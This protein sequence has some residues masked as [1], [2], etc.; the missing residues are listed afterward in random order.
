MTTVFFSSFSSPSVACTVFFFVASLPSTAFLDK[1]LLVLV[2][3]RATGAANWPFCVFA[4]S[5]RGIK[6]S[7]GSWRTISEATGTPAVKPSPRIGR[8]GDASRRSG[9]SGGGGGAE[10]LRG[11]RSADGTFVKLSF[12]KQAEILEDATVW[13]GSSFWWVLGRTT[14]QMDEEQSKQSHQ[15]KAAA[16]TCLLSIKHFRSNEC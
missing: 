2:L 10:G 16:M 11:F 14:T 13:T 3:H 8:S 9:F 5:A 1:V 6:G 15:H 4:P 12:T 7:V